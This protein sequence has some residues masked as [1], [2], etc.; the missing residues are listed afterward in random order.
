MVPQKHL[1]PSMTERTRSVNRMDGELERAIRV[2]RQENPFPTMSFAAEWFGLLKK[3]LAGS[4]DAASFAEPPRGRSGRPPRPRSDGS[5][6]YRRLPRDRGWRR[7][8]RSYSGT[9]ALIGC[10][11]ERVGGTETRTHHSDGLRTILDLL[12]R[13]YGVGVAASGVADAA[14]LPGSR[15]AATT[16]RIA[17][18]TTSGV[19]KTMPWLLFSATTSRPPGHLPRL[20]PPAPAR[21]GPARRW[22]AA[23]IQ[24]G[25]LARAYGPAPAV[26]RPAA[27]GRPPAGARSRRSR[28][29]PGCR[30]SSPRSSGR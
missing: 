15:T 27:D 13:G 28:C 22:P 26:G 24:I 21:S 16:W 10:R 25:A 17:S 23:G 9:W 6:P 8:R 18:I 14:Q 4:A 7:P 30:P 19:S 20:V 3:A 12:G 5:L 1:M 29:P 2:G 11:G